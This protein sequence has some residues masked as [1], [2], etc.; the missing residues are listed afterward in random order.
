[1]YVILLVKVLDPSK[2]RE[3]REREREREKWTNLQTLDDLGKLQIEFLK[4]L[5][6]ALPF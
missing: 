3:R 1:M 5:V 2:E 4:V 6:L